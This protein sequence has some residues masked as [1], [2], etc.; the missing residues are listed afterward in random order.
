MR[1]DTGNIPTLPPEDDDINENEH[2]D[3]E[4]NDDVESCCS[5]TPSIDSP[6]WEPLEIHEN[7]AVT[8]EGTL[9][10][11]VQNYA[12]GLLGTVSTTNQGVPSV[13]TTDSPSQGVPSVSTTD[14]TNQGV[15]SVS[16]TDS[17]NQGVP[18]VSTTDT[19]NRGVPSVST[20]DTTSQGVPSVSTTNS[21]NQ[22]VPSVASDASRGDGSSHSFI[23][24]PTL[25][26]GLNFFY[27]SS[28]II[29]LYWIQMKIK[30][31]QPIIGRRIINSR[32]H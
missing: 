3:T 18:S 2:E 28:L 4:C 13:S 25:Q 26:S 16:T 1:S 19:T 32:L 14:T 27:Y 24:T 17:P 5:D 22:G 21:T 30:L 12:Y 11:N 6:D 8:F 23:T 10:F 15:P 31:I 9:N 20:T 7:D 29:I